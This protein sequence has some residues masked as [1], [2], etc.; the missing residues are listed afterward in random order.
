MKTNVD[1]ELIVVVVKK[2]YSDYVISASKSANASGATVIYG[3]G[4]DKTNTQEFLGIEIQPEKEVVFI[5]TKKTKKKAIMKAILNST[6]LK[7]EGSGICFSLPITSAVGY[8]TNL[9]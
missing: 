7:K 4:S 1:F 8:A 6:D 5:V 9:T 2:G 3:H